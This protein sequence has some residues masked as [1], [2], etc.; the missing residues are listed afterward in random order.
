MPGQ[1]RSLSIPEFSRYD[2]FGMDKGIWERQAQNDIFDSLPVCPS[3]IMQAFRSMS[4]SFNDEEHNMTIEVTLGHFTR[5]EQAIAEIQSDG[6]FFVE[7]DVSPDKLT[8]TPHVHAHR[9]DIY[10]LD[11]VLELHEPDTGRTHLLKAGSKAVVPAE[12]LHSERSPAAFR[13]AFGVSVDP[14]ELGVRG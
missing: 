6:L 5:R 13:A 11:G 2:A 9:V 3:F 12:T 14:S 8:P 4:G 1:T 7:A 10:L